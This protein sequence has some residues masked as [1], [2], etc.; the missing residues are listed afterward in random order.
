MQSGFLLRLLLL[1]LT[2]LVRNSQKNVWQTFLTYSRKEQ[3][4]TPS[5][6]VEEGFNISPFLCT[7]S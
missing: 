4:M 1:D 7:P 2:A 6:D 5:C 3:R